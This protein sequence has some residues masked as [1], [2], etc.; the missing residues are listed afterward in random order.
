SEPFLFTGWPKRICWIHNSGNIP[1]NFLFEVDKSGNDQ[2]E[3]LQSVNL[4]PRKSVNVEF[5]PTVEAE[6]IRVKTDIATTATV[7]FSYSGNDNRNNVPNAIFNGLSPVTD[8]KSTGGLL[9]GLGDNRR[10]L[11]VLAGEF[12]GIDFTETGYYELDG[13]MDLQ[14]KEDPEMADFIRDKFAIPEQVVTIDN[15]SVLIEDDFGRRWRL[16]KGDPGFK[17]LTDGATLRICREVVTER[18]LFNC[19]GTF[20]ELP[21]NNADGFAKIRPVASHNFRIHDYASYRGMLIM[22]GI[23]PEMAK[24]NSHVIV[25]SDGKA[26]VWAGVIDDLWK[27]G[28]PAGEGGPWKNSEVTAGVPSYPYLIGFYEK[29]SLEI[30]HNSSGPVTIRIETEPV[31]HGLWMTYMTVQVNPGEVYKY[32]FPPAFESRWIRFIS[33]KDCYATAWLKYE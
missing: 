6:W 25:S 30:S 18:D 14:K 19:A 11:G 1:V 4:G 3:T 10:A 13:N 9:Y 15:A 20:Y 26:A 16:P 32:D 29:R 23:N 22:T 7:H 12:N 28:K 8:P 31:G 33:D 5:P 27:I 17:Y 2:W 21:A 24:Q